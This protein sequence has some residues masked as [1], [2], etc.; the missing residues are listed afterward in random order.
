VERFKVAKG[1]VEPDTA[2]PLTSEP[3]S[4]PPKKSPKKPS[5]NRFAVPLE[6][7]E[8]VSPTEPPGELGASPDLT[9]LFN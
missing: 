6:G 3:S 5:T 9:A 4:K 1:P 7:K 8:E 2:V